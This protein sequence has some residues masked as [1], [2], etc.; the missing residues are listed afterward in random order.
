MTHVGAG[1]NTLS[2]SYDSVD[3]IAFAGD[4]MKMSENTGF[5][6]YVYYG[7]G[8]A[9]ID[10]CKGGQQ[11][12]TTTATHLGKG[13]YDTTAVYPGG[14]WSPLIANVTAYEQLG[15]YILRWVGDDVNRYWTA[16]DAEAAVTEGSRTDTLIAGQTQ[17]DYDGAGENGSFASGT[18]YSVDD[19]ITLDSGVEV[20]VNTLSGSAVATFTID[21]DGDYLSVNG[22]G[23]A[24]NDSG[25]QVAASSDAQAS[26]TP[27][28]G[29][30]FS[31]TPGHNNILHRK[32]Y[33]RATGTVGDASTS[34]RSTAGGTV[35]RMELLQ[36]GMETRYDQG[37]IAATHWL[38]DMTGCTSIRFMGAAKTNESPYFTMDGHSSLDDFMWKNIPPLAQIKMVN[39]LAIWQGF[40][41][42]FWACIPHMFLDYPAGDKT[43]LTAYAQLVE[44]NLDAGNGVIVEYSNETWNAAGAFKSQF[45]WVSR[46]DVPAQTGV[47]TVATANVELVGHGLSTGD[48]VVGFIVHDVTPVTVG[49]Y[50]FE[51]YNPYDVG[52]AGIFIIKVDDD[53]FKLAPRGPAE[54]LDRAALAG[55]DVTDSGGADYNASWDTT[56][57][58]FADMTLFKWKSTTAAASN[59]NVEHAKLSVECWDVF[60][61]ICTTHTVTAYM[62]GQRTNPGVV[63]ARMAVESARHRA[64]IWGPAAYY[65]ST[66]G[67]SEGAKSSWSRFSYLIDGQD[68]TDYDGTNYI[69]DGQDESWYD[70]DSVYENGMF[71]FDGGD[72]HAVNDVITLDDN[73]K[74]TVNA[75]SGGGGTGP[76]TEFTVDSTGDTNSAHGFG[77]STKLEL[78]SSTGIG[79]VFSLTIGRYNITYNGTF[80]GGVDHAP[81]DI[82]TMGYSFT[83]VA[84]DDNLTGLASCLSW[85]TDAFQV[86]SSGTLPAPLQ[87]DTDYYVI[88][89]NNSLNTA[90]ISTS[91][92][93][94]VI[95]MTDAGTGIHYLTPAITVEVDSVSTGGVVDGFTVTRPS[96]EVG[97]HEPDFEFP[98]AISDGAGT[99]F[100]L[101]PDAANI[102]VDPTVTLDDVVE[103]LE[104]I[105]WAHI[106]ADLRAGDV[107]VGRSSIGLY[108]GYDAHG[109]RLWTYKNYSQ[110]KYVVDW[111]NSSQRATFSSWFTKNLAKENVIVN[112]HHADYGI[113]T[114][115][116]AW[117]R[118]RALRDTAS[119]SRVGMQEFYDR[120][121][122]VPK[123]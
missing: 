88:D 75:I 13:Y 24:A 10:L 34:L 123:I 110:G 51:D 11:P 32:P 47:I 35:T 12:A 44:D 48:E 102:Q 68:E 8:Q 54:D 105:N 19:V 91:L 41:C 107:Q 87:P 37:N 113:P 89:R 29:T 65:R 9:F 56:D 39:E 38:Q 119:P 18:G 61:T 17:A 104:T 116:G 122:L 7:E 111:G 25:S 106:R 98:Q 85:W 114:E 53:N 84:D 55:E 43:E 22:G 49:Q 36:P 95:T 117:G 58:K 69:Q 6:L 59:N 52:D 3:E 77:N 99:G 92:E 4:F 94:E 112:C 96:V 26:V 2:G 62:A 31:L 121:G 76:V 79:T 93:G 45:K 42:D 16:K 14:T 78:V 15:D 40:A 72:D 33:T 71:G 70:V 83:A 97:R 63:G 81:G 46:G 30:G 108:E 21:T 90:R 74:V 73:V 60:D 57:A 66:E 20:T 27:S 100:S 120:N 5:S 115:E 67:I 50:D 64:D 1:D 103:Y 28:G 80:S 101:T 118:Y 23:P 82:I 86:A 109:T